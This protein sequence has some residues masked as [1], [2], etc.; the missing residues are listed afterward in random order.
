MLVES[1]ETLHLHSKYLCQPY[2][3]WQE[4]AH[5]EA[6]RWTDCIKEPITHKISSKDH[7]TVVT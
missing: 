3:V 1:A 2:T 4:G 6:A 5:S 7:V